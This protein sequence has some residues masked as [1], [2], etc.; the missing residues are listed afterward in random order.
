MRSRLAE[1]E[2]RLKQALADQRTATERLRSWRNLHR[3][4]NLEA[5]AGQVENARQHLG[6]ILSASP[7]N[8][9]ALETLA[10]I[11]LL[12]GAPYQ[13]EQIYLDLTAQAPQSRYFSGL[14][15]ARFLLGRFEDAVAAFRQALAMEPEN[16]YTTLN[17]ADAEL[18]LGRA[19]EAEVHYRRVLRTLERNRPPGGLSLDD[20]MVQAQCLAHLGRTREAV[21]ITQKVLFQDPDD[22]YLLQNAAMVYTLVGDLASA[23][24]NTR[25]AIEKG[26]QPRLFTVPAFAPLQK[27]PELRQLLDEKR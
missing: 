19:R 15:G 14:G 11:E 6:E 27:N 26:V 8:V 7:D 3:L 12:F 21:E 18:S 1:S 10:N 20:S 9:W 4:A 24:V 25:T 22:P 13:A 16:V 2:G 5:R 23:L 17:L